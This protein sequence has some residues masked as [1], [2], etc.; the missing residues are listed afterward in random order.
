MEGMRELDV[1]ACLSSGRDD[2][3]AADDEA[4][5]LRHGLEVIVYKEA[6]NVNELY[7]IPFWSESTVR[8]E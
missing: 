7:N 8:N 1:A 5:N 2:V 3:E 6:P 4:N